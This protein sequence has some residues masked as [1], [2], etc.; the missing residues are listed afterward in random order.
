MGSFDFG[1]G[2]GNLGLKSHVKILFEEPLLRF[3]ANALHLIYCYIMLKVLTP[4]EL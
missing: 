2:G 3:D 1:V 4:S